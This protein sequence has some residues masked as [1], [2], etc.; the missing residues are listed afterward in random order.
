MGEF[1]G[2][3]G[4]RSETGGTLAPW[5]P[6]SCTLVLAP[7]FLHPGSCT[8]VLAPRFLHPGSCTLVLAPRFLLNRCG[9]VGFVPSHP[10]RKRPRVG[11]GTRL[12][13]PV[14]LRW[15][16]RLLPPVFLRWGNRLLAAVFLQPPSCRVVPGDGWGWR[17]PRSLKARGLGNQ[18]FFVRT[19]NPRPG[20]PAIPDSFSRS[21]AGMRL[22][23]GRSSGLPVR[24]PATRF[25]VWRLAFLSRSGE[26]G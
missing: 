17:F 15:G 23:A 6:G 13:P 24:R 18:G 5:H 14:F 16:N 12:L 8:P 10:T 1:G 9:W 21:L 2:F 3:P 4:L 19:N 7:R 25:A 26:R 11:W 22:T 20:R